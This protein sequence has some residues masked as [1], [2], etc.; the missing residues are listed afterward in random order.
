ETDRSVTVLNRR[1]LDTQTPRSAPEALLQQTGVWVQKTNHGGG[2]PVIRGMMGNQVL[3]LVDGIRM[4][5]ATYRFGPNQ[6]LNT[7]DPYLLDRLEVVRGGGSVLYGSDA[8]GGVV[9][10]FTRDP[11]F[12]KTGTFT[13]N[14]GLLSGGWMSGGMEASGN[15]RV[16]AGNDRFAVS[17]AGSLFSFGDLRAGG[18]LGTLAPTGYRQHAGSIR[19]KAR[20]T[21]N[22]ILT[23]A[24]QDLTQRDVPR[25]D[26]VLQGGYKQYDFDPQSRR[27]DYLRMEHNG[28]AA[29]T[30]K[31]ILTVFNGATTEGLITQKNGANTMKKQHDRVA[32]SGFTAELESQPSPRWTI[33]SGAEYYY[34]FVRSTAGVT[35]LNTGSITPVR[36]AYADGSV[37]S[38]ASLYSSHQID[39]NRFNFSGG[40]RY[41]RVALTIR[42]QRFGNQQITPD[43]LVGSW[44][45]GWKV[46]EPVRIYGSMHA[47][48]RAPNVDDLSKFGTVE[49]GIFEIPATGLKPEHSLSKEIGIKTRTRKLALSAAWY[50]TAVTDLV[51]RVPALFEGAATVEGRSVYQKANTGKARYTG[52]EAEAE[53]A[54]AP[55]FT[56]AGN[57]THT[58]GENITKH[59]PARRIPPL[60]GRVSLQYLKGD[61]Q[62][63]LIA[64]AAGKQ[65]RLAAG[66]RADSRISIRL[67]DGV[68]PGWST[69]DVSAGWTSGPWAIN[70]NLRNLGNT[71]Y[72]IYG[73]GVDGYGRH[74]AL[75]LTRRFGSH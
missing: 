41:T 5:N 63:M 66:D 55:R 9:Q 34:D 16:D 67:V 57:V 30:R 69:I 15:L 18:S 32:T 13:I 33:R 12:G 22:T 24:H 4:N 74:A 58:F 21:D 38:S 11:R 56:L 17:A 23:L 53:Y 51:D 71:A 49:S 61:F 44:S 6:Y 10:S 31:L 54:F 19:A 47:G 75:R 27:L 20:I 64:S 62:F 25:Y 36:G 60:F 3:L 72:R 43:A 37:S 40:L 1:D 14:D 46:S 29:L 2:S 59:E 70:L 7:I 65:D 73:S 8:M 39:L 35:D 68:M 28:T 26:Q 45:A 48:F 52:L 42:D 50:S